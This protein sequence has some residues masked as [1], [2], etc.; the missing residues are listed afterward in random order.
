MTWA[1]SPQESNFNMFTP[2]ELIYTP[3]EME[4]WLRL[5]Q[6]SNWESFFTMTKKTQEQ[7]LKDLETR[8]QYKDNNKALQW[9][10]N[11]HIRQAHRPDLWY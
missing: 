11:K 7:L 2:E 9:D 6:W 10:P 4:R 1:N 3:E 8:Q 5:S